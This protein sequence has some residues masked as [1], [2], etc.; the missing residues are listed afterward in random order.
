M[1]FTPCVSHEAR[2]LVIMRGGT[3]ILQTIPHWRLSGEKSRGRSPGV[4]LQ[5][6]VAEL[7]CVL[8]L[9]LGRIRQDGVIW[10][11]PRIATSRHR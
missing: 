11:A 4:T 5:V 2:E 7:R 10:I 9:V 3:L 8:E 1:R 6:P